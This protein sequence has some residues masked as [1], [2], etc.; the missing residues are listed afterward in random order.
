MYNTNKGLIK[1]T[2][3]TG[4]GDGAGVREEEKGRGKRGWRDGG[5]SYYTVR[6]PSLSP[7]LFLISSLSLPPL[8][9]SASLYVHLKSST[10]LFLSVR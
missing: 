7:P 1:E 8:T 4:R 3:G 5:L 9:F 2:Q 10:T 6:V